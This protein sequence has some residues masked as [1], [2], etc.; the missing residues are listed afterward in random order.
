MLGVAVG[1]VG[2]HDMDGVDHPLSWHRLNRVET[3]RTLSGYVDVRR[4]FHLTL[5]G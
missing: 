1:S 4:D 3:Y 2:V 5:K